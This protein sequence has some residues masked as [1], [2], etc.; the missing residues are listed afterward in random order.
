MKTAI[1]A[2]NQ[3][4]S[5]LGK[6][7]F[8][9]SHR[10]IIDIWNNY[11]NSGGKVN[12]A[13]KLNYK[14]AWCACFWSAISI[15]LGY[16][17]IMPLEVSCGFM[18]DVAKKMGIWIENDGYIPSMGDAVLYDWDDKGS[19]D[20][21][22]WPDHIGIVEYVNPSSGYFTVIEGNYNDSV[23][24]RTVSI[25]GRYIRGFIT[26]KYDSDREPGYYDELATSK[27]I[28]TVAKE[29][30]AGIYGNGESRKKAIES[31]G[32]NYEEVRKRV[33]DILNGSAATTNNPN[34]ELDQNV[35]KF[36]STTCWARG[37]EYGLS[38]T[39]KTTANLYCRNDAGTNKKALCKIPKGVKV[40]NY[41]YYTEFHGVR[42]LLIEVILDGIK[43]TGFSSSEYLEKV[44]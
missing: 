26:P 31:K 13:V 40:R 20:N 10:E 39:Y 6:N 9:G 43:Y 12:R 4:A 24:K 30:I 14:N 2:I 32:M 1:K 23:K 3:A 11:V 27:D 37:S 42:W 33:N 17:N 22:G 25:N 7:E 41:G 44:N 8:D 5:W 29:V 28:D 15:K 21:T 35:T 34:Q 36:V 38:G 18:I 19:G 16:T